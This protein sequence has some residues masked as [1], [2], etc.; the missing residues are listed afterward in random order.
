MERGMNRLPAFGLDFVNKPRRAGPV[1]WAVLLLVAVAVGM[2]ALDW[3]SARDEAV[4]WEEKDQHWQQLLKRQGGQRATHGD[5]SAALRPQMVA[6]AKAI[7]LLAT[8]WGALYRS[9]EGSVDDSVSLLAVS[10]NFDKGEVRLGGEAKDFAALRAYIKR[11]GESE[12]LAEVRLL[13]QEV[14]QK[15]PE[16]PIVFSILAAWRKP[17]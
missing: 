13:G 5:N 4:R 15:D 10:P 17:S 6:A 14:K 3:Q 16:H 8:P 12:S 2:A 7:D 9:L 1:G 11:L